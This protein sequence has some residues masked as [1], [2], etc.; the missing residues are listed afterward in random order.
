MTDTEVA[1][2]WGTAVSR[3]EPDRIE[4][5]GIPV[6]DLIGTTG[7][8]AMIWL[9]LRGSRPTAGQARLLEAALVAGVDHG[10]HAPSIAVARIAV[11]CGVGINNA[12]A[13]AI[14]TLGDSH[15]GAGQQCV[16]LLAEIVARSAGAANGSAEPGSSRKPG[17]KESSAAGNSPTPAADITTE[18]AATETTTA[19]ESFAAETGTAGSPAAQ[20][21]TAERAVAETSAAER[22]FAAS[23]AAGGVAVDDRSATTTA[24]DEA[25]KAIAY[26]NNAAAAVADHEVA[27]QIDEDEAAAPIDDE[28]AAI[29][30]AE[31][32]AEWRERGIR[33]L[34]GFGHRFHT[35][36]PRRDPLLALVD[37]A[38]QAGD[39][40]GNFLRAARAVEA[41]LNRGR[42][43]P[44]PMNI[45]G[46]TAVIYAELGFP[47]PLARGLFVLSRSVGVLAHTWEE[48]GQGRRNKGPIPP[49]VQPTYLG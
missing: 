21:G 28:A 35:R 43:R 48:M 41:V 38:V 44:V 10:P 47:A 5:R 25:A 12:M 17:A 3:I 9:M 37:E 27:A 34:P 1:D 8:G 39:V 6:Q 46:A 45:D 49:A 7:F 24:R 16:E 23:S 32:V 4:L 31:V 36:D 26:D 15:G 2:W 20:T 30:A 29:A 19:A 14:N 18:L 11:T 22:A 42:A 33:Y 40:E 13:S